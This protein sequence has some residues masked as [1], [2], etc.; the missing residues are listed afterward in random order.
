MERSNQY[1]PCVP[2]NLAL[3]VCDQ[4]DS[5]EEIPVF[6]KAHGA[7]VQ[8]LRLGHHVVRIVKSVLRVVGG[9]PFEKAP[10]GKLG[11]R[12]RDDGQPEKTH[13]A[14]QRANR[15]ICR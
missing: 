4:I 9:A 7:L 10:L 2:P 8:D 13:G 5:V 14:E 11:L 1:K 15:P 6:T 12:R 3:R